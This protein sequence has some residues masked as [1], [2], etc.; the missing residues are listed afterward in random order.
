MA[1]IGISFVIS[2]DIQDLIEEKQAYGSKC[3][4]D[5]TG[6][7]KNKLAQK[8]CHVSKYHFYLNNKC[9]SKNK[10]QGRFEK[11]TVDIKAS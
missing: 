9:K 7:Y 2:E 8:D 11:V 6:K 5:T 4:W 3:F 10:K 1:S